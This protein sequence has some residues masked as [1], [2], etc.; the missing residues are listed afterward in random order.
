MPRSFHNLVYA[1]LDCLGILVALGVGGSWVAAPLALPHVAAIAAIFVVSWLVV[2]NRIG[3][4]RVA[5]SRNLA[6]ALR[7]GLEAWGATWGIA[8]VLAL[9][10]FASTPFSVWLVLVVG[11]GILALARVAMSIAPIPHPSGQIKAVVVGSCASARSISQAAPAIDMEVLGMVPFTG[12]DPTAMP[13]LRS[14]GGIGDLKEI[15]RRE[16]PDLVMLSPSDEAVTGDVRSVFRTCNDHGLPVQYFPSFL[17]VDRQ[18]VQLTWSADRPGITIQNDAPPTVAQLV[19]RAIDVVGAAAGLAVLFPV[20]AV[21][22]TAIKLSSPGPVLFRQERVGQGGRRF[23]C[24]KF[25]TMRVGAHAQQELLRSASTQDGPAFKLPDD[26]RI[27][28]VGRMLRK[29]SIDELPQLI[30]V[31]LGDM[32]LVGPRPPIPSE[33]DKYLWWQRRRV[34]VKPGLTCLWQVYGRN[35]VSFKRWVEM[36]L[37]Y[38]DNWSLWMDLKL[39]AHTFRAVVRGTGM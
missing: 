25:R 22:A 6:V 12:E 5:P 1:A 29:F 16:Q 4:Y 38:I 19:K 10:I 28:P 32:S 20:F 33:V 21:C 9:S 2:A 36:D 23:P 7:R 14:L 30:N 15:L 11:A 17:D 26:P 31:L 18:R 24:L 34:A 3:A 37:Y 13:H 27:T 35:R 8:G 39:I